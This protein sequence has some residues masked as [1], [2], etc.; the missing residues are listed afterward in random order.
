MAARQGL[1]LVRSRAR[2]PMSL[3]YGRYMLLDPAAGWDDVFGVVR[4]EPGATLAETELWLRRPRAARTRKKFPV[5]VTADE[6][7]GDARKRA[8]V[9]K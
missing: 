8:R 1:M 7:R 5:M 6:S 9:A 2:D 3:S 4:G